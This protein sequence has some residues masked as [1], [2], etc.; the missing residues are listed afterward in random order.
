MKKKMAL[1]FTLSTV[2]ATSLLAMDVGEIAKRSDKG[3]EK[4]NVK[5]SAPDE[6]KIPNNQFGDLVKYGKELIVHTAK[7]IGPEVAD[8]SMRF[9]GNNLSCQACH[10]DAGTKAYS[11]PYYGVFPNFPQ[12]RPREDGISTIE[13]RINGCMQRSMNG[14]PLPESGKEMKAMVAYMYWLSQGI[15][16]GAKVEGSG[17][18]KIDRKVV[19]NQTADPKKGEV[20]Y[21]QQCALCHGENGEGLKNEGKANGYTYPPLWGKDT[22]NTG[23]GM[24]RLIKAADFIKHNMPLGATFENPILTD[25]EAYNVAA[26]INNYDKK[27]PEKA[28]REKD[29]PDVKVKAADTDMGPYLD[30]KSVEQHKF[31][32]YNGII[33]LPQ[34]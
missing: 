17:L 1:M 7:Y 6:N 19:M 23:A 4:M 11:A 9:A 26:Y 8:K 29:F 12:Y 30:D 14:K 25:E 16:I 27:R 31:G 5:W 21:K 22:Y 18:A 33:I 13:A 24:Y 10:L 28:N 15:P 2:V 32:P 20:V 34:K 3:F